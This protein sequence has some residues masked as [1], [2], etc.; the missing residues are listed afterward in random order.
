LNFLLAEGQTERDKTKLKIKKI[1]IR[2]V[3]EK[4]KDRQKDG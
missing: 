4:H 3:I 1:R 2:K